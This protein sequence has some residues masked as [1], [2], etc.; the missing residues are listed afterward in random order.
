MATRKLLDFDTPYAGLWL[1]G[2]I[3]APPPGTFRRLSATERLPRRS[4][5]SR[6]GSTAVAAVDAHSVVRFNDNRYAGVTTTFKR[7][8]TSADIKTGLNGSRLRFG[9]AAPTAGQASYLFVVNGGTCF[10]VAPD[11]TVSN[12]G[13]AA[14]A[15]GFT[16]TA[17]SEKTTQIDDCDDSGTWTGSNA[18]L[19]TETT[20]KQEGTASLHATVAASTAATVTKSV[21][22][23]LTQHSDLSASADEDFLAFWIRIDK[24]ANVDS[25]QLVFSLNNTTF[26][27]NTYSVSLE[28]VDTG[29]QLST[30]EVGLGFLAGSAA[31]ELSYIKAP[32]NVVSGSVSLSLPAGEV[33]T[34]L[35]AMGQTKL[36]PINGVW[37]RVRIPKTSFG[38]SGLDAVTWADVQ[39]VKWVINTNDRGGV[40]VYFDDLHLLG[41]TGMQGTYKYHLTFYSSTTGTRSNPNATPV[42]V[43]PITRQKVN[44]ASIPTTSS[45]A[46][47]DTV[48]IWRTVGSGTFFFKAGSVSLG[49]S[50]FADTVADAYF[51][52]TRTSAVVLQDLELPRT[53]T[54]PAATT[55]DITAAPVNGI[56][57]TLDGAA[58]QTS[59]AFYSPSAVPEGV[60]GFVDVTEPD[61]P[62]QRYAIWNALYVFSEK[63]LYRLDGTGPYTATLITGVP[64]TT[65][66]DTVTVTPFGIAY[67]ADDGPRLFD[68][69]RSQRIAWDAVGG[70]FE[71][72]A[73][74]DLAAMTPVVG[75][76]ARDEYLVG[77][78]T[79]TLGF[80]LRRAGVCRNLGAPIDAFWY[81]QDTQE[82]LANANGAVVLFEDAGTTD[83]DGTALA[84]AVQF[85]GSVSDSDTPE[86]VKRIYLDLNTNSQTLTVATILDG[87]TTS[88]AGAVST[89]ARGFVEVPI[90]AHARV[91]GIRLSGS[92]TSAVEL[93][94][95]WIDTYLARNET[96]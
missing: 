59:R 49:T 28:A 2:G 41:E 95:C 43:G 26:V 44:L 31:T 25:I 92:L 69:A 13:I 58:G 17:A 86:Y 5:R 36:T 42:E 55:T 38:R 63:G 34:L 10:K 71:G 73:L 81:E 20:I 50:T 72:D 85:S 35:E 3:D 29:E 56:T 40:E 37:T 74:E 51:M 80:N 78:G 7:L 54:P 79:T 89:S 8:D 21:T 93:F 53:N 30:S 45:D 87:T 47:V 52:D 91:I 62:L 88:S 96:P 84:F 77:D 19:A 61:D 82:L 6:P 75:G 66:P 18:T 9:K 65:A 94:G 67:C 27:D 23:D 48:E 32:E 1:H 11:H 64:G 16:A 70:L 4:L 15:D 22:I 46:Q 33:A 12:M 24:P 57:W 60:D 76:F 68:G 14:P 83:D 90:G 39:A